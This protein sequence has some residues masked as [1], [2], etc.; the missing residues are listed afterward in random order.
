MNYKERLI[1]IKAFVFDVDG[2]LGSDKV[3]LNPDGELLRTMNIKDGF[4]INY[5]IRLGYKF[6]IITGGNNESIRTRFNSLGIKDIYLK[7]ENKIIDYNDFIQKNQITD[8]QVLYMGDDIP[9]YE[10]MKRVSIATC[11]KSAAEEI[12]AICH[13]ISHQ[14]GGDGAVR[15]VVRQVLMAQERWMGSEAFKW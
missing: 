10:V 13:Y 1:E 9:D 12:K 8:S 14:N 15:D 7:S 3:L 5:A 11:P 4:A 2:V 6:A